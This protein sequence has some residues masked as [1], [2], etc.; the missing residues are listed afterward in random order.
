MKYTFEEFIP[1]AENSHTAKVGVKK[2]NWNWRAKPDVN[3]Y[4]LLCLKRKFK[5]STK[6]SSDQYFF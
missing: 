4:L 5:L 2:G 1:G 3:S 6:I